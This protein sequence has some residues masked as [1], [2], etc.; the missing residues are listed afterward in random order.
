MNLDDLKNPELQEK[1][2]ACQTA[3]EL[4]AIMESEGI[5]LTDNQLDAISGG[6]DWSCPEAGC[7]A[8]CGDLCSQFR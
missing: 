6:F 3:E 2:R 5:G 7:T 4:V 1:L 8:M